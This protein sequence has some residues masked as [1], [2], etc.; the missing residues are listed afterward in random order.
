MDA[1][2]IDWL[3]WA[4]ASVRFSVGYQFLS[5]LYSTRLYTFVPLYPLHTSFPYSTNGLAALEEL[6]LGNGLPSLVSVYR[7]SEWY[8]RE[9]WD[10]FGITFV[11]HPDLRRILTDYGFNGF[12]LRKGFPLSGYLE[13]YYDEGLK[14]PVYDKVSF[15]Q[16]YRVINFDS[17]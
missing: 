1:L 13:L 9:V 15:S 12:P 11:N 2:G 8:E 14:A 17:N 4:G 3:L 10:M 6:G 5:T 16:E 7:N